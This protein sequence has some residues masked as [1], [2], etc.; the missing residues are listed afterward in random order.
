MQHVTSLGGSILLATPRPQTAVTFPWNQ[1]HLRHLGA[2][3]AFSLL[4]LPPCAPLNQN[5]TMP[6]IVKVTE[7]TA[8]KPIEIAFGFSGLREKYAQS[9][10][11]DMIGDLWPVQRRPN[12]SVYA[13]RLLGDVAVQYPTRFSPVVYVGEGSAYSRLYGHTGWLVPLLISVPQLSVE[14]RIV[15]VARKNNKELYKHIEADLLFWFSARHGALPWFNR[16]RETSKERV[17]AYEGRARTELKKMI[18]VGSGRT[19]RWAIRPTVNNPQYE[20]YG[21]GPHLPAR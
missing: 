3:M 21:K 16:Q 19:Y 18:S 8:H 20:P 4:S 17:Y 5:E 1:E 13:I 7:L 11:R 14:I 10:M 12:Q 2:Q 15:E 9:I 6:A